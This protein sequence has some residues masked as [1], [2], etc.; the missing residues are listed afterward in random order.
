M[1]NGHGGQRVLVVDDDLGLIELITDGLTLVGGHEV[2]AATDG[3]TGLERFFEVRP[4][5]VVVDVQM[6]GLNGYQFVRALRGDAETAH[7]PIIVLS[8]MAQERDM[9]A[10][11]L[12][13][14][15][16]YLYK[17]VKMAELLGTIDHALRLTAA[18]RWER[19]RRLASE[20]FSERGGG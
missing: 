12:S 8:A 3:A 19:L 16:A 20:E 6:P 9:L 7:T 5:C 11:L 14:A 10:G 1:E 13:G 17:P 15:D 18:E 2:V 4:D